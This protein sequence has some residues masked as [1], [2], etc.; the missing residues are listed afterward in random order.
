MHAREAFKVRDIVALYLNDWDAV[1]A[2]IGDDDSKIPDLGDTPPVPRAET[3]VFVRRPPKTG[4]ESQ[5]E[6][7]GLSQALG[8]LVRK[9][10][11]DELPRHRV[12]EFLTFLG[13]LHENRE[14][15]VLALKTG[16]STHPSIRKW[17]SLHARYH[18]H[19]APVG[20]RFYF[21]RVW[22][23]MVERWLPEISHAA[24]PN[25]ATRNFRGLLDAIGDFLEK[26]DPQFPFLWKAPPC[27]RFQRRRTDGVIPGMMLWTST[28]F[29]EMY[30]RTIERA[31]RSP[32]KAAAAR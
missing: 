23:G 12:L 16:V 19:Y 15:H 1:A 18:L 3:R 13:Q 27:G 2:F 10:G 8:E 29:Q 5:I 24:R 32:L 17:F 7:L 4:A 31:S 9:V 25:R 30:Q 11:S 21:A 14:V 22:I 20:S 28:M 6:G 26:G